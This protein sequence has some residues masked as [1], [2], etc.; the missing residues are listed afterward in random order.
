MRPQTEREARIAEENSAMGPSSRAVEESALQ[1]KLAV[2]QSLSSFSPSLSLTS[3]PAQ[4]LGLLVRDIKA[5]GH[6]LYRSLEDQLS[7]E[8]GTSSLAVPRYSLQLTATP[9]ASHA[10]NMHHSRR[11]PSRRQ[12]L[13]GAACICGR[14]HALQ[15]G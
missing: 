10:H 1:A 13:H 14:V 12:R 5:D 8:Q 9:R 4:P 11:R 3:T 2:C 15:S 6:C 7:L